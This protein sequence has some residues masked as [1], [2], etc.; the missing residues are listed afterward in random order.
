MPVAI[1]SAPALAI[2]E[3]AA[4][5]KLAVVPVFLLTSE[6]GIPLPIP[7]G[8]NLILPMFLQKDRANQELTTFEK[9]N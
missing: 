5:K 3:E 1:A 9:A 6:K 2:P 8:D 7:R 4:I